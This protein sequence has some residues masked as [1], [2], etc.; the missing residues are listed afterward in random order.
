MFVVLGAQLF[1]S[2]TDKPISLLDRNSQRQ[3]YKL[4][5][6]LSAISVIR[7]FFDR[8]ESLAKWHKAL[9]SA[10]GDYR[11]ESYYN[12]RPNTIFDFCTD[13]NVYKGI[14]RLTKQEVVIKRISKID[15]E[16]FY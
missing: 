11:I 15:R 14:N 9:L 1:G 13:S 6:K 3:L 8:Q 16:N 4:E 5:I 7:M 12:V 2:P 10:T